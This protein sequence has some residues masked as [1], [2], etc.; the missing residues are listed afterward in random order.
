MDKGNPEC[1]RLLRHGR[2]SGSGLGVLRA[3]PAPK[4]PR[5]PHSP[6]ESPPVTSGRAVAAPPL[7]KVLPG[8]PQVCDTPGGRMKRSIPEIDDN[9][10]GSV[11]YERC[12]ERSPNRCRLSLVSAFSYSTP[13][14]PQSRLSLV[15][16]FSYSTLPKPLLAIS[17]IGLFTLNAPEAVV[18]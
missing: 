7:V 14:K 11:E 1:P 17:D 8:P 4:A 3:A 2:P 9:G 5:A 13:P 6:R 16:A 18:V 12:R 10:F 15:S